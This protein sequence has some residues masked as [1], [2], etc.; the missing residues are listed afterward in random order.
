MSIQKI[1]LLLPLRDNPF[2]IQITGQ[3]LFAPHF[4]FSGFGIGCDCEPW[5]FELSTTTLQGT[6]ILFGGTKLKKKF[7]KGVPTKICYQ[8]TFYG[9]M[10]QTEFTR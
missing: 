10:I 6:V 1:S 9:T 3:G 7:P 5:P 4:T 8:D 2:G